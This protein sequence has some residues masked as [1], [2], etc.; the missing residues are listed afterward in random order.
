VVA[1]HA[2]DSKKAAVAVSSVRPS[3]AVDYF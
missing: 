3:V 1:G 2:E